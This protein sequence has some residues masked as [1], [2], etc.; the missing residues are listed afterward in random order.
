MN[1]TKNATIIKVDM[2]TERGLTVWIHLDY[3]GSGQAF[4]GF[5]L[6]SEKSW[7][8]DSEH[9]KNYAGH[10]I[11]RVLET[12]GTDSFQSLKGMSC[13]VK[14]SSGGVDA[15]GHLL[16]DKWFCPKDELKS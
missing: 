9:N 14:A 8:E 12:V 13:R 15:I 2:D 5:V 16:K 11:S 1:I 7:R 10:F 3:G 6:Y 4:G